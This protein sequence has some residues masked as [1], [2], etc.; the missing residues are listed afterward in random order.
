MSRVVD[1]ECP[2]CGSSTSLQKVEIGSYRCV[3]CDV[4]F[5]HGDASP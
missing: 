4:T 2:E 3:D 1:I 5:D